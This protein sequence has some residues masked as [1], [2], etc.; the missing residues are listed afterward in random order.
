MR[1]RG[2]VLILLLFVLFIMEDTVLPWL[3][4]DA[5][6]LRF[7]PNLV[8]VVILF[9]AVYY[10]RH[11]A[12][13]LG[14]VF[15][16]LHDVVF[17]GSMIGAYSFA[18]GLSAY[19]MGLV[20]YSPRALMPVMMSVVLL[21]SLLLDSTIF[22]IYNL[23]QLNHQTFDWALVEYMVPDLFLHFVFALII[24]VPVR[25]QLERLEKRAKKEEA[26]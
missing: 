23:F 9:V 4:P 22:G 16:L 20:F 5:W 2:Q 24:Y 3:I 21:G 10:S 15:G 1:M 25:K 11:A 8:F 18:M 26:V 17:Y 12:L 14:L 6:Q 19:V 7:S 13:V